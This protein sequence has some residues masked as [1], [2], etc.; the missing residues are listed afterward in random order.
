[1]LTKLIQIK[2]S[3]ISVN[4]K[5]YYNISIINKWFLLI[6]HSIWTHNMVLSLNLKTVFELLNQ[7]K[8]NIIYIFLQKVNIR[9]GKYTLC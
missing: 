7:L 8:F 2:K 4:K 6:H 5:Q 3:F 1:M 9:F